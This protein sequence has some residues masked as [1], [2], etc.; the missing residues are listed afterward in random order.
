MSK[1][2][3]SSGLKYKNQQG[4]VAIKDGVKKSFDILPMH[5]QPKPKWLKVSLPSGENYHELLQNVRTHN[6]NTV[7]EES[8]CPNLAEC[9]SHKTATLMVLGNV[10]TRACKFCAVDTGNPK[11][12]LDP[13]E[14]YSTALSVAFMKL[15][16][17]VLTSVDRDDLNDGGANHIANCVRQIKIRN[18]DVVVEALSPDFA[19][20]K[21]S[22]DILL[23]S[24]LDVFSQNIETVDRLTYHVR[25]PRAGYKQTLDMLEHSSKKNMITKSGMMLGLGETTDEVVVAMQ[26]LYSAGVSLL[27][28]G[29]YLRP[30]KYHVAMERFVT[31]EEFHRYEEIGFEL[32]FK[33]VVAG[34]LVR[35]SYRAERSFL[36]LSNRT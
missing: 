25:D 12:W 6:L 7:C 17:V 9:W 23:A 24:G 21:N 22:L 10:C 3:T 4:V 34:P 32:G 33:E 26:D 31:P 13:M 35:S 5:N 11:G 8:K 1:F 28:L 2:Q 15:Q 27:T 20:S 29:Q 19:G 14:P 36:N 18:P 30:T 16:Y